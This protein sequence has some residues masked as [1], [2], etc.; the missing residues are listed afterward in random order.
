[1]VLIN[2]QTAGL[3]NRPILKQSKT[4]KM[5]TT[6]FIEDFKRKQFNCIDKFKESISDKNIYNK[7]ED[8]L[9]FM[10]KVVFNILTPEDISEI[11]EEIK[12]KKIFYESF[13]FVYLLEKFQIN[14][15]NFATNYLNDL[16]FYDHYYVLDY[17]IEVY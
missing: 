9:R 12:D 5:E 11:L 6:I 4:K 17:F 10:E 15:Y 13:Y 16:G 2:N 14:P 7:D 8:F 3:K 1:M